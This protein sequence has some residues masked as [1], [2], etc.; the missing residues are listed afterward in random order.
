MAL[1]GQ[2][3]DVPGG[4]LQPAWDGHKLAAP[5]DVKAEFKNDGGDCSEGEY[6]QFVRGVFRVNDVAIVHVLCGNVLLDALE[7]REDGCPPPGCTAYG[8]RACPQDPIDQYLPE[9]PTGCRFEMWDAPGLTADPGDKLEIDLEF[10]G[11]LRNMAT[12]E[13]LDEASWRVR[14]QCV[15]PNALITE[16]AMETQLNERLHVRLTP[17]RD[18]G[19]DGVLAVSRRER[20]AVTDTPEVNITAYD[21]QGSKL[22]FDAQ[23]GGK[24]AQ[25]GDAKKT[26]VNLFFRLA[27]GQAPAHRI[28]VVYR[29][30]SFDMPLIAV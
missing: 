7:F 13:L 24:T 8:R 6:R 26:T 18:G 2:F 11:E 5:F 23:G 28:V 9:R 29:G 10:R 3:T 19:W 21:A 1:T 20:D 15:V 25:A 16:R 4:T 22:G 17:A 12:D 30:E 14:G 27:P